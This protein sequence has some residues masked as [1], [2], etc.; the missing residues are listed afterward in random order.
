[1][2]GAKYCESVMQAGDLTE[3]VALQQP[4]ETNSHGSLTT[5]YAT[6]RTVW[7]RVISERGQEALQSARTNAREN[8]RVG[9]R[10]EDDVVTTWRMQWQGNN[11]NI[12]AVDR[13]M[14]QKGELWVTAQAVGAL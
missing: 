12:V 10:Y 1:M 4:T 8:I 11:Y 5:S 14:R 6:V 3:R 9:M 7:A 2:N 13:S